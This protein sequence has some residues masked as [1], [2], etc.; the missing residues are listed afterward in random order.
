MAALVFIK[1]VFIAED[2]NNHTHISHYTG[3][4]YELTLCVLLQTNIKSQLVR[5]EA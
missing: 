4:E 1:H 2:E 3:G 5:G